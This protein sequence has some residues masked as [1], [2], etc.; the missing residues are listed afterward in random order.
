MRVFCCNVCFIVCC[1]GLTF[2]FDWFSFIYFW[3]FYVVRFYSL[4]IMSVIGLFN[5]L[6]YRGFNFNIEDRMYIGCFYC[7]WEGLR[8]GGD[9]VNY[10]DGETILLG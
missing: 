4:F 10:V 5:V 6:F 2:L 8:L 9:G 7:Y 1:L 3:F